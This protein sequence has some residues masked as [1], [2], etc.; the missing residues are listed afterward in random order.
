MINFEARTTSG[1]SKKK[2]TLAEDIALLELTA[3]KVDKA[4]I[5]ALVGHSELS[6]QY[7]LAFITTGRQWNAKLKQMVQKE[8]YVYSPEQIFKNHKQVF[9]DAEHYDAIRDEF[10]TRRTNELKK[11]EEVA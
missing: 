6:C 4:T 7:R 3:A 11:D 5:A 2:F 9:V 10:I 1:K 8:G